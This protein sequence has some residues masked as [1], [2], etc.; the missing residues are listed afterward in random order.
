MEERWSSWFLGCLFGVGLA[1]GFGVFGTTLLLAGIG[2]LIAGALSSRSA[3]LASGGF[4]GAGTTYAGLLWLNASA[5]SGT[6]R[7]LGRCESPDLT[8]YVIQAFV[9]V[10]VGLVLG[11]WSL[12]RR[13][14]G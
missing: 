13:T 3:A 14:S 1:I 10:A 5:C 9:A 6:V 7:A 12:L 11:G 4:V 8:Q 2:V